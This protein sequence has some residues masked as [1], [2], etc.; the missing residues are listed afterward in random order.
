[1]TLPGKIRRY[2]IQTTTDRFF[3][4]TGEWTDAFDQAFSFPSF[5]VLLQTCRKHRLK[6]V[7]ILMQ[8]IGSQHGVRIPLRC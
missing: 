5:S 1:M 8:P 3:T 4:A 6:N 7:E 2:I